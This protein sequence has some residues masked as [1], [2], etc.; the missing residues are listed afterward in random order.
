MHWDKVFQSSH[1]KNVMTYMC[2]LHPH[3]KQGSR[4]RALENQTLCNQREKKHDEQLPVHHE[5]KSL[6]TSTVSHSHVSA[7]V[8]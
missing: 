7:A 3:A 2:F 8:Q 6:E 1:S 5:R 4:W